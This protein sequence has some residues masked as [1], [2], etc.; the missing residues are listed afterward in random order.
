[1]NVPFRL[2][3]IGTGTNVS[4][5]EIH[6]LLAIPNEIEIIPRFKSEEEIVYLN[7]SDVF[8]LPSFYEGKPL[9]LLQAMAAGLCCVTTNTCGQREVI[10]HEQ[11]GLLFEKGDSEGLTIALKRVIENEELRVRLS[12]QAKMDIQTLTWQ[13]VSRKVVGFI[14]SRILK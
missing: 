12:N 8:I 13:N 3:L 4:E 6:D 7:R 14:E 11:N 10:R 5:K 1:M 2:L 9:S